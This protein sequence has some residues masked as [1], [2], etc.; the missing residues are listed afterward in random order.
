MCGYMIGA[1]GAY[2]LY[3]M[4]KNKIVIKDIVRK[5]VNQS[6]MSKIYYDEC[7][8]L[9]GGVKDRLFMKSA[10]TFAFNYTLILKAL[11]ILKYLY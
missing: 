10:W 6:R 5:Y 3:N 4:K 1:I 9:C 8:I 7:K 2:T 11:L